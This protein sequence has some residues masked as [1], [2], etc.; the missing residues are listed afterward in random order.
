LVGIVAGVMV[1]LFPVGAMYWYDTG[2]LSPSIFDNR[3]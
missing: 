3:Y 2:D 1:I